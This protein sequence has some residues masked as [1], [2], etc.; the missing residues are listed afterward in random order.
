MGAL[1]GG[2]R[3]LVVDHVSLRSTLGNCISP[4]AVIRAHERL[5]CIKLAHGG[6]VARTV[7]HGVRYWDRRVRCATAGE[8]VDAAPGGN[9]D[10]LAELVGGVWAWRRSKGCRRPHLG[11]VGDSGRAH[12]RTLY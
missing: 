4:R 9:V 1:H 7:E 3:Y 10:G 5:E 8:I 11:G 6:G 2:G 12:E